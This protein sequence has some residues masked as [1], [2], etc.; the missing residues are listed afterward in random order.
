MFSSIFHLQE[1]VIEDILQSVEEQRALEAA[2]RSVDPIQQTVATVIQ[3]YLNHPDVDRGQAVDAIRF[4]NEP[5]LAVQV[6]KLRQAYR[7]FQVK[8]DIKT[9]LNFVD[10]LRKSV[11]GSQTTTEPRGNTSRQLRREDLRLICFDLLSGA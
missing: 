8:D 6:R 9:V 4:L 5:L 10:E 11:G 2:P 7:E 1:K 3:S